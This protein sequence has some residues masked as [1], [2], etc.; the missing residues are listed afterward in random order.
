METNAKSKTILKQIEMLEKAPV[1]YERNILIS[2]L[3]NKLEQTNKTYFKFNYIKH[4]MNIDIYEII[5]KDLYGHFKRLL[6]TMNENNVCDL[7]TLDV[8][9]S[10]KYNIRKELIIYGLIKEI[11][12]GENVNKKL[13]INPLFGLR[14]RANVDTELKKEFAEINKRLFNIKL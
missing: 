11:K 8:K 2:E 10:A 6:D 12:K 9:K 13:Y 14:N 7:D 1:S 4:H 5:G 3:N